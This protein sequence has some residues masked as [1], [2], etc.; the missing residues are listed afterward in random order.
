MAVS[1][2]I[3]YFDNGEL[4]KFLKY[5]DNLETTAENQRIA[6]LYKLLLATGLR[7]GEALALKFERINSSI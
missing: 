6:T 1:L 4:K 5:L 3:K 2:K 7:V